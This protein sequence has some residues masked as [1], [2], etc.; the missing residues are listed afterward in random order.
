MNIERELEKILGATQ[1]GLR[2]ENESFAVLSRIE[3]K[4]DQLLRLYGPAVCFTITQFSGG[5]TMSRLKATFPGPIVGTPVGGTSTFGF[6]P[7]GANG[8]PG[9][10]QAGNVPAITVDDPNVT[11]V[12]SADG[13]SVS[14]SVAAT[15]TGS[16]YNLTVAGINSLG[17]AISTVFNVPILPAVVP[18]EQP[19]TGFAAEQLS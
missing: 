13:S 19:A 3:R 10:L 9:L 18:P 2:I 16:S 4:L 5:T 17:A 15:D 6:S 1:A 8:Q 14:A 11:L 12:P 7:I